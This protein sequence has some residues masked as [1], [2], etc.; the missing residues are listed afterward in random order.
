MKLTFKLHLLSDMMKTV[1]T[2]IKLKEFVP[3]S[4]LILPPSGQALEKSPTE[5][6]Y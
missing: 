3:F 4:E 1:M 6:Y 5:V 2:N